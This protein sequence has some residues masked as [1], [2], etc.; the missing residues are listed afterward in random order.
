MTTST[1]P[2]CG[3]EQP[4]RGLSHPSRIR[5]PQQRATA[6][7]AILNLPPDV[8]AKAKDVRRQAVA[9]L[10]DAGWSH[11]DVAKLLRVSRAQAAR[12]AWGTD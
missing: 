8:L 10:R 3:S 7:H 1:C 11:A 5:D 6:A 12:I 4:A 2:L 9:E